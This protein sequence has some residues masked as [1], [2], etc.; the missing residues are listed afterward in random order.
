MLNN[1][2]QLT[3]LLVNYCIP[4]PNFTPQT[5]LPKLHSHCPFQTYYCILS[6]PVARMCLLASIRTSV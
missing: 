6:L 5:S 2:R 4:S 1:N 3:I